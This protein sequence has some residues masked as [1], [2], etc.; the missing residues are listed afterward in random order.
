RGPAPVSPR[1]PRSPPRPGTR[2]SG[3]VAA[4]ALPR[5]APSSRDY[6]DEIV[7]RPGTGQIEQQPGMRGPQLLRLLDELDPPWPRHQERRAQQHLVPA[8]EGDRGA[9][10]LAE[11]AIQLRRLT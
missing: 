11:F 7:R 8:R 1:P 2:R 10:Q 3:G 9:G 6:A 5:P 4:A